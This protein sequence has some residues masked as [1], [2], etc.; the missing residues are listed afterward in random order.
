[1][2]CI[3]LFIALSQAVSSLALAQD[4]MLIQTRYPGV[5]NRPASQ[6][7]V[8]GRQVTL[9]PLVSVSRNASSLPYVIV[10]D[11]SYQ[12]ELSRYHGYASQPENLVNIRGQQTLVL[13]SSEIVL[14]STQPARGFLVYPGITGKPANYVVIN[15]V[16]TVLL[17]RSEYT[18]YLHQHHGVA[19]LPANYIMEGS[20]I[21]QVVPVDEVEYAPLFLHQIAPRPN[22]VSPRRVGA[23]TVYASTVYD[24]NM[25]RTTPLQSDSMKQ[26]NSSSGANAAH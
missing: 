2:R 24:G 26:E 22:N 14:H 12:S 5:T 11:S 18:S 23:S 19:G 20:E 15:G 16:I 7:V 8:A 3:A 9:V 4:A 21:V 10:P 6:V 1:M 13:K 25:K 17:R